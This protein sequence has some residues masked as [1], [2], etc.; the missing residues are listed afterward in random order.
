MSYPL[1][2]HSAQ[3]D[4]DFVYTDKSDS[5]VIRVKNQAQYIALDTSTWHFTIYVDK[6][7]LDAGYVKAALQSIVQFTKHKAVIQQYTD[8][9]QIKGHQDWV[10]W[11]SAKPVNTQLDCDNLF[12]Y[13]NGKEK[14][15]NSWVSDD[16]STQQKIALYKSVDAQDNSFA[17]WKDGFDNP[18]LSLERQ[19]KVNRY[20]FYSRFAP[21]WSNLVW[22]DEFPKMLLR[23]IV[24]PAYQ[25]DVAHDKRILSDKQI[26]PVINPEPSNSTGRVTDHIHLSHYVWLLLVLIFIAERWLAHKKSA[27]QTVPNA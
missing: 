3:H 26:M 8:A 12:S 9:N 17:I 5:I 2:P 21:A 1:D 23:L 18:V 6:N 19:S 10:F 16:E 15:V 11:L 13:E 27:K 20:H 24:G 25:P 22:N 4:T 7:S 14:N